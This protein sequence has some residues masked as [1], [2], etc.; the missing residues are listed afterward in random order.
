MALRPT[1]HCVEGYENHLRDQQNASGY[2]VVVEYMGKQFLKLFFLGLLY[3]SIRI[4]S[5]R[6]G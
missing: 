4:I 2:L 3:V 6:I 5:L 1:E